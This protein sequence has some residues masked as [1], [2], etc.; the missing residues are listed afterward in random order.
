MVG[1]LRVGRNGTIESAQQQVEPDRGDQVG[2][3]N[4]VP[5]HVFLRRFRGEEML[6]ARADNRR[7]PVA[8]GDGHEGE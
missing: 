8:R 1:V 6:V 2:D 5:A 7:E 4:G 3:G